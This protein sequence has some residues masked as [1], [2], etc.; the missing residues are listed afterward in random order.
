MNLRFYVRREEA[1]E[2]RRGVVFIKEIVPRFM[3]AAIAR[4][5][6]GEPY[7]RWQMANTRTSGSVEYR[8]QKDDRRNALLVKRG[9]SLGV[10]GENSHGE[11]IIDHY[12]GYTKRNEGRTDEYRVEHPKWELFEAKE[13]RIGVR[14]GATY[15]EEFEFLSTS[16]PRSVLLAAGSAITVYKGKP[17]H[18]NESV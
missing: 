3:I 5:L 2:I 11:F 10:P 18:L 13:P 9:R 1:G 12:W 16:T 14:F 6:Y 17:I 7:E 4:S 15:G 8:W